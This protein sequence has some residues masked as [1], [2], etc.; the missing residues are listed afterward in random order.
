VLQAGADTSVPHTKHEKTR[1]VLGSLARFTRTRK[2]MT[3][4]EN[5]QG[6]PGTPVVLGL[7]HSLG[8][9]KVPARE[10]GT[11]YGGKEGKGGGG[12]RG[13]G[14]SD[15]SGAERKNDKQL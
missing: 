12:S 1:E 10:G 15:A 2:H 11:G 5:G 13:Q 9:L 8:A 7:Q 3:D 14:G 4:A 6:Q